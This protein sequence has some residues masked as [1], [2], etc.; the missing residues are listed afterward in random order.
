MSLSATSRQVDT[1]NGRPPRT[2]HMA[3]AAAAT[4]AWHADSTLHHRW[5]RPRV[6][7]RGASSAGPSDCA[8]GLSFPTAASAGACFDASFMRSL[9]SRTTHDAQWPCTE[10]PGAKQPPSIGPQRTSPWLLHQPTELGVSSA[11]DWHAHREGRKMANLCRPSLSS[12]TAWA[13]RRSARLTISRTDT[14]L[15]DDDDDDRH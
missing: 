5:R 8:I 14:R 10:Q 2:T 1:S 15:D 9:P 3:T 6:C 12:Y 4:R 13:Q 11:P 7:W